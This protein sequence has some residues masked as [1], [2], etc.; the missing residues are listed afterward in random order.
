MAPFRGGTAIEEREWIAIT[1]GDTFDDRF[2]RWSPDGNRLYFFS[3]RD[4][5]DC[6]WMQQLNPATKQRVG[7]PQVLYH[8]HTAR[9]AIPACPAC[10]LS[11]A[12]DKAV[13]SLRELTGNIWMAK[14]ER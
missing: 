6:L 4:G 8:L 12:R 14:P 5:S 10:G 9:R 2:P 7:A 1:E 11:V 13:F 3:N